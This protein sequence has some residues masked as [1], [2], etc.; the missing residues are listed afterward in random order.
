MSLAR[1]PEEVV[2]A[3]RSAFVIT[4]LGSVVEELVQNALDA[5]ATSIE[6]AVNRSAWSC[7]VTDNGHGILAEDLARLGE[8][9]R[10]QSA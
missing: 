5:N 3:I 1:L 9:Y 7:R 10:A 6:I 4:S 8:R 2:H